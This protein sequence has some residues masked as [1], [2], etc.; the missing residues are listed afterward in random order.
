MTIAWAI[1]IVGVLYFVDKHHKWGILLK[2]VNRCF[3]G[4]MLFCVLA[5]G[6]Q[7]ASHELDK[8][9]KQAA[10]QAAEQA[11]ATE[12][13]RVKN[14]LEDQKTRIARDPKIAPRI[15]ELCGASMQA[16]AERSAPD[17]LPAN[18]SDWDQPSKQS[19]AVRERVD[20]FDRNTGERD[21]F[22]SNAPQPVRSCGSN[23]IQKPAGECTRLVKGDILDELEQ[24][25]T[26][27]G[28]K[29]NCLLLPSEAQALR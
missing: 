12:S 18:F 5:W 27:Y 29:P 11:R 17:T 10:E 16:A 24:M 20:C 7:F 26:K 8:L 2:F 6:W 1:L 28:N 14:C 19:K 9:N 3:W 22:A 23:Y 4:F 21:W 25:D 15:P 13:E